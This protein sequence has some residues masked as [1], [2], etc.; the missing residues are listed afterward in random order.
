M[1]LAHGAT[2]NVIGAIDHADARWGRALA[3]TCYAEI[4]EAGTYA[5]QFTI[6]GNTA[7]TTANII[8]N[9]VVNR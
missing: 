6:P 3:C 5:L 4:T 8:D 7:V 9:V 2:T 1:R